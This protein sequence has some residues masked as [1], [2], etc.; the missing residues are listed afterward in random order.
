MPV[1]TEIGIL[2][3]DGNVAVEIQLIDGRRDLFLSLDVE[4]P[5]GLTPSLA[6]DSIAVQQEWGKRL[7]AEL[8]WVRQN[9]D[10][11]VENEIIYRG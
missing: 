7:N 11:T 3:P 5:L 1:E 9:R 6:A 10:G 8:C 2:Y 4:N